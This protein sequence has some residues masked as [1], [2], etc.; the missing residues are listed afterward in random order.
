MKLLFPV[1]RALGC[2]IFRQGSA[3]AY[4]QLRS[5]LICLLLHSSHP[6]IKIE[7]SLEL[8]LCKIRNTQLLSLLSLLVV[9]KIENI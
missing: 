5:L 8:E 4:L 3:M 7:A 1:E 6:T 9:S 2:W